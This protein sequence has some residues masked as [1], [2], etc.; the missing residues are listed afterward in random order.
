MTSVGEV[1]AQAT[2]YDAWLQS[3]GIPLFQYVYFMYSQ[4]GYLLYVGITNNLRNRLYDHWKTKPWIGEVHRI[5]VETYKTREEAKSRE[6][7]VILGQGPVY[8]IAENQRL[9]NVVGYFIN[10]KCGTDAAD[11]VV[12]HLN[13]IR[14]DEDTYA[15]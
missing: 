12:V 13:R 8:N 11:E 2:E 3:V 10:E 1:E 5:E 6:T 4:N 15:R 7:E 9:A 14:D